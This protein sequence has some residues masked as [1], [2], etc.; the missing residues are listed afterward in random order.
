M[1]DWCNQKDCR[2]FIYGFHVQVARTLPIWE[3]KKEI[4]VPKVGI[5]LKHNS[6]WQQQQK[7]K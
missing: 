3:T 1:F 2:T 4:K 6:H 7:Q 5:C